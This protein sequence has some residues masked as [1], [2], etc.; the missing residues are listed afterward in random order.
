M[1]NLASRCLVHR[2]R[3]VITMY[4]IFPSG[5]QP[6]IVYNVHDGGRYRIVSTVVNG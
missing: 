3:T 4:N 5:Q 6:E 1:L 2:T